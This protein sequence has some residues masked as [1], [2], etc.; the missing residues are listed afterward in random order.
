MT[1]KIDYD[2]KLRMGNVE[3]RAISGEN[4]DPEIVIYQQGEDGK[5]YCYTITFF[6][7]TKEGY[8]M[9]T[10]G[11]RFVEAMKEYHIPYNAFAELTESF[12]KIIDEISSIKRL[13]KMESVNIE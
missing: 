7:E 13:F 12:H 5:E 3:L 8:D 11:R 2:I 6:R 1:G 10:V 4:R 9:E